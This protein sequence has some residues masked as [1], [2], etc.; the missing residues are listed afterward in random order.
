MLSQLTK[1]IKIPLKSTEEERALLRARSAMQRFP[2]IE[3]RKRM[4][5]ACSQA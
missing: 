3:W 5:G 2:V 4:E 1:M